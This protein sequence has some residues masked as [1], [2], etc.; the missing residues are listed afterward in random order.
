[1]LSISKK[2]NKKEKKE[3][4]YFNFLRH[5]YAVIQLL[6]I[7]ILNVLSKWKYKLFLLV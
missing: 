5:H 4:P 7:A 2:K 1:M 6:R 3:K